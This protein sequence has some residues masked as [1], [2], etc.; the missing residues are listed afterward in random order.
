MYH[1]DAVAAELN[2]LG[3]EILDFGMGHKL[4]ANNGFKDS[5]T[6]AMENAEFFFG[7]EL[8]VVEEALKFFDGFFGS[9]TAEVKGVVEGFALLVHVV[10]DGLEAT[11]LL[12]GALD[13]EGLLG[14]GGESRERDGHAKAVGFDDGL[15]AFDFDHL[16][17]GV[18]TVDADNGANRNR[19]VCRRF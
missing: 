9:V 8:S 15:L 14:G 1:G 5:E 13:G 4:L 17:E 11:F 7:E 16:S 18:L 6:F 12:G 2:A 19:F 3:V 10:V